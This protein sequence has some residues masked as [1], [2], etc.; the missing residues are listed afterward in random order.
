[1]SGSGVP[2]LACVARIVKVISVTPI[3]LARDGTAPVNRFRAAVESRH[4]TF[5]EVANRTGL[6][7]TLVYSCAQGAT[8]GKDARQRIAAAL[9][10][11]PGDL[12]PASTPDAVEG[13]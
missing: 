4:L 5:A 6:S 12:W 2:Y 9:A 3:A 7:H 11:E 1:M 13:L 10:L 8:P